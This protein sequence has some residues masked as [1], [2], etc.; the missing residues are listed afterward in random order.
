[1]SNQKK[2]FSHK[3]PIEPSLL[4]QVVW[5]LWLVPILGF[6]YAIFSLTDVDLARD[7][8]RR[9][10]GDVIGWWLMTTLAG[11]AIFPLMFRLMPALA[12]RGYT[13]SRTAGLML[14]GFIFWFLASIGLLQ[15]DPS[16]V[17]FAWLLVIL[18][19]FVV[20]LKWDDRPSWQ[21]LQ[22]WGRENLPVIII[23]EVLFL[24]AFLVW[25]YVRAHNPEITSTEKPMEMMFING[26]R[27]SATFPPQDPWL[28]GYSISYYYFGYVIAAALADVSSV[29][30]AMAF[31]LMNALLFALTAVGAFGV[32]YNLV[33]SAG[34]L[35]RWRTG[36]INAAIGTGLMAAS[37]LVLMGNLGTGLVE[38]PYRGYTSDVPVLD[39]VVGDT[40]FDFWDVEDR[41]GPYYQIEGR[42]E[43]GSRRVRLLDT[44]ELLTLAPSEGNPLGYIEV[45]DRDRDGTPNWD[46]DSQPTTDWGYW[47]WFRY[48]RVVRDRDLSNTPVGVQPIA[49]VPHFS[50]ILS[51]NHPHVLG[52]PFTVLMIGLAVSLALRHDPLKHWEILVYAVFLGG[53]IFMN[54][55]DAVYLLIVVGAEVLRRLMRN[56]TGQLTGWQAFNRVLTLQERKELNYV[57]VGPVFIGVLLF[58]QWQ[59]IASF[60][61]GSSLIAFLVRI[62]S[63]AFL[64]PFVTL[65]VNWLFGDHDWGGIIRLA[66]A[67]VGLFYVLYLP[68]I[69]SFSSQANGFFPNVIH[70]TKTQQAFLQFG[71]FGI[72]IV[73]FLWMEV[74]RAG[75]RFNWMMVGIIVLFGLLLLMIVPIIS[76]VFIDSQCPGPGEALGR[77]GEWACQAR[78]VLLGGMDN[79]L[80][81]SLASRIFTRRL[82]AIVG[83]GLLLLGVS[84]AAVRL[85]PRE[86]FRYSHDTENRASRQVINYSPATGIAL[87]LIAAGGIAALAPDFIYLRD[88]FSNRINTIFKLYYQAWTLLSIGSAYA[89]YILL[90]DVPKLHQEQKEGVSVP[91]TF[92]VARYAYAV[93]GVG[94]IMLGMVY[95]YLAIPQRMINDNNMNRLTVRRCIETV[96][97]NCGVEQDLTLNG[98]VLLVQGGIRENDL[99]AMQCLAELEPHHSDAVL[100]E[101]PT[102]A[103][104]PELGRFSMYT[105]IPTVMGWDNHEAQWRGSENYYQVIDGGQRIADVDRLYGR[106]P[107]YE[108]WSSQEVLQNYDIDAD[109]TEAQ[110]IIA[111]YSIDY[112]VVGTSEFARYRKQ[113]DDG[114]SILLPGVTKFGDLLDPV[115]E[116]GD[117][118]VYR[119]SPQ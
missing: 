27:N 70:P 64:A 41:S 89:F 2:H 113:T 21:E 37:M 33:R 42:L 109:W 95:P 78:G 86:I 55:W 68:W 63:A 34:S 48:S 29:P 39:T 44:G 84:I 67:L 38:L 45:A 106:I 110:R 47:W 93:I 104:T 75:R 9:E 58:F 3:R 94:I 114:G 97:E 40:Y 56:G 117:V 116:F 60:G 112:V 81:A 73:P 52:L 100:V 92:A 24:V 74:G 53:M 16:A 108:V 76:G 14:T 101:A 88:N 79:E 11:A 7:W 119:V 43:D 25:A 107:Q 51:D 102:G 99:K 28:S 6:G 105:G 22:A 66:L 15:N 65:I 118:A 77:F 50:F 69:T 90:N 103:Y 85:F 10:G 13:L 80:G 26:I 5:L 82:T 71:I 59:G 31:N 4:G 91:P 62:I 32:T 19:S 96:N 72:L 115:C 98:E 83:E 36:G 8:L 111:K 35:K 61:I 20:W 18:C 30:T 23:T 49:E 57:L 87:L 12:D 17:V 54:A 1:M 46:D